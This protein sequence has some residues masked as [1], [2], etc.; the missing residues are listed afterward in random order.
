MQLKSREAHLLQL[1]NLLAGCIR[2]VPVLVGFSAIFA[3]LGIGTDIM[4]MQPADFS[5]EAMQQMLWAYVL[6]GGFLGAVYS[7]AFNKGRFR[8][9][10]YERA[11]AEEDMLRA[12]L[13]ERQ[14]HIDIV[15]DVMVK[16]G[17]ITDVQRE[18]KR[19]Q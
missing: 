10:Y 16:H 14:R 7:C 17:L 4:T 9:I 19:Y 1:G 12:A 5:F 6:I 15:E 2:V 13:D 3:L 11:F 18:Q 8:N